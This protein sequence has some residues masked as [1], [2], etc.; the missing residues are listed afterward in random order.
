[1][2]L[3]RLLM[4]LSTAAGVSGRED[5]AAQIITELFTQGE[6]AEWITEYAQDRLGNIILR[7]QGQGPRTPRLMLA[8]HIDEI[9]LIV[10]AIDQGFLRFSTVGGIDQRVLLGQE[11]IV[12]GKEDLPGI[13]GAKPPHLQEPEE[14]NKAVEIK[15]L[16]IDLGLPEEKIR[17]LVQIGDPITFHQ[18]CCKLKN[19]LYTGKAMDDRAGV[20]AMVD[21]LRRLKDRLHQAEVVAVVTVQEELGVRGAVVSSYG[22]NPDLGIALDVT[23]GNMPGL[24]DYEAFKLG[25]GPVIVTGPQVHP[26][27]FKALQKAAEAANIKY[28]VEAE[29]TPRGT[30]AYA[31][32]IAQAG[33]ATGLVSIP[34]RYMHTTVETVSLKD[35]TETSRLLTEFIIQI[36]RTFVEGLKCY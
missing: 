27:V 32:Q 11:V 15:D 24:A 10:S 19:P 23:H 13:I 16:T 25:Q 6:G 26:Q 35:I 20:V 18:D 2:N 29:V 22:V 17:A 8:A 14:K 34:L 1:M 33:V 5:R 9:G 7:K 3:E 36:D 28:Q 30:D 12:H 4:E 31:L 21:C